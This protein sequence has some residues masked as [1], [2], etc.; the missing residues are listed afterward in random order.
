[1]NRRHIRFGRLIGYSLLIVAA[2]GPSL[3][4]GQLTTWE[5]N[6]AAG[7]R[8]MDQGQ[9]PQATRYFRSA[10]A[11]S[12]NF[13]EEDLRRTTAL[14]NLARAVTLAGDY[15]EADALYTSAL[16]KAGRFLPADHPYHQ[17]YWTN[18]R[19]CRKPSAGPPNWSRIRWRWIRTSGPGYAPCPS[20]W[21]T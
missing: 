14:R 10:L 7:N 18:M 21:A 2:S 17:P 4:S 6:T 3:L 9:L 15:A 12:A 20:N 16:A 8:T 1:M 11:L 5:E 19:L 13:P